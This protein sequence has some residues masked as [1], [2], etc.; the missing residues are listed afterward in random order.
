ME[1]QATLDPQLFKSNGI[2]HKSLPIDD[3]KPMKREDYEE[4]ISF[5]EENIV[6]KDNSKLLVSKYYYNNY[7]YI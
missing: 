4:F 6:K 3:Y 1:N 2:T 7:L 5:V